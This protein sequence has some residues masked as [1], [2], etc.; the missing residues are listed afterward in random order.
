MTMPEAISLDIIK[1]EVRQYQALKDEVELLNKRKDDVKGRIFQSAETQG[2]QNDRGHFVLEIDDEVSGIKRVVKQRRASK[3]FNPEAA[4][5]LL[6]QK[7]LRD[8]CVKTVELLDE[9]AIMAAYYEGKL[10]DADIDLM[11]PDKITWALILE[12]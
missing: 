9:D 12:K 2:E 3:S 5:V 10:T 7:E 11:F 8:S 1:S 4:E 6:T